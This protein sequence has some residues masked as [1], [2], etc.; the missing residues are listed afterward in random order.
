M[1]TRVHWTPLMDEYLLTKRLK[2]ETFAAIG[3]ALGVSQKAALNRF[4]RRFPEI[5]EPGYIPRNHVHSFETRAAVVKMKQAG[6]SHK[7]IA[8]KLGLRLFQAAGIWNH[9]RDYQSPRVAA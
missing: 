6:M 2:A 7:Q 9:W 1:R 5:A 4:R 3:A 8:A